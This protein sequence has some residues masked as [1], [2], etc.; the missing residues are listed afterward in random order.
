MP[1]LRAFT[2]VEL[3]I[4]LS[5]I[6]FLTSFLLA[7]YP[8]TSI[9]LTLVNV[10]HKVSLLLRE[11]QIRGSAIDSLNSSLGG[12]GVYASLSTPGQLILFGD[13]V[14]ASVPKPNGLS[15]GNGKYDLSPLNE[16][17]TITTFPSNYVIKKLCAG[18]G[19][20]FSCNSSN[21]PAITSLTISF[22]RPNPAPN[23]YL[24]NATAS[25]ATAACI[26]LRSPHAPQ[27]GH[28]KTVQIYNSGL[29]YITTGKCDNSS[30]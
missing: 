15:L 7:K 4:S 10:S 18:T 11:A 20:P 30:S 29:I 1:F 3:L 2:L 6:I 13:T 28:I 25:P 21:T 27:G 16:A 8:D 26:E 14:D 19:F 12:Y 22:T 9:R 17:K 23:I 5:I 24:N